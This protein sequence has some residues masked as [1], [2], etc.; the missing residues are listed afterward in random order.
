M[1]LRSAYYT[2]KSFETLHYSEEEIAGQKSRM[3]EGVLEAYRGKDF[4]PRE[5]PEEVD[6]IQETLSQLPVMEDDD[7]EKGSLEG[8]VARR[9]SGSSGCPSRI[10]F[11]EQAHDWLSAVYAR[12]LYLHGYRPRQQIAQF[13]DRMHEQRTQ[14]GRWLIPKSYVDTSLSVHQQAKVLEERNPDVLQYFPQ[15]LVAVAKAARKGERSIEP[16]LVLTYGEVLT[17]S[18]REL[19]EGTFGAEVRDQYATTEFGTAAWECP[20]G[21]YHIAEDSVHAEVLDGSGEPV[22]SGEDGHLVLTTLV[23]EATPLVRYDTGDI[24]RVSEGSCSCD[25][26][27]RKIERIRGRRTDSFTTADGDRVMTD[28]VAEVLASCDLLTYQVVAE[29]DGYRLRFVPLSNDYSAREAASELRSELGLEPLE[30]EQ[31][32]EIPRSEGGKLRV[33]ENNHSRKE[34]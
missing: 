6:G 32:E 23:N 24:V 27:F 30:V 21:G 5:V 20:E 9:T 25:T 34:F 7:L 17:P 28:D 16:D 31:V 1:W 14:V 13:W 4:S 18:M 10:E 11:T 15:M 26:S 33:V 22:S 3:L 19:I 8:A 29:D 12:T 2:A